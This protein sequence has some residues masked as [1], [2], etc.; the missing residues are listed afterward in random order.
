[1]WWAQP[2]LMNAHPYRYGLA[3]LPGN[4]GMSLLQANRHKP[5]DFIN[6]DMPV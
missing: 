1:M 5:K 4:R 2:L 6:S 3:R